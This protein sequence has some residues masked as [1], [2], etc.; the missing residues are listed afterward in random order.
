MSQTVKNFIQKVVETRDS[1]HAREHSYRPALK[2]LFEIITELKVINEPKRSEY[3]APDFVFLK[4]TASKQKIVIAYA[5]AKDITV[6]LDEIEKSEQMDRYYGYSNIIL[7]NGLDF[8]FY[9]NTA[10]YTDPIIIGKFQNNAIQPIESSFQLLEDTI[11]DFITESKEP[12]KSGGVLAKV[13]AGKGRRIRDN[14]KNYLAKENDPKNESLLSVYEVIKKLL[15]ADLDKTK[16]ADMYA[17]TLVYGLFVAKYYDDTPDTFSRQEARDLVPSSNPF[18]RHFFDHIAG[19]SFDSRIEWIVNE[20]CEEFIHADVQAIVHNYYK[21]EKEDSRDPII[22]FYEDFL[23]E[24]DSAERKKMGVFYTPLPVVRFIVRSVDDILKKEFSLPQGLVDSSR[25]EIE[26]E[27]QGKKKKISVHKVQVLDPATGTGTFLNEAILHIKKSFEGQEGRWS[28]YVNNDLL[29]RLHGFE[30]MMASYTI[31]H[32]KL[33]STLRE[34]G[35]KMENTRL[36]IY[37]TN[38]LEKGESAP[39]TLFDAFGFGKAIT[40]ESNQANKVKNELP[41]MVVIGNPPYSGVSSNETDHANSLVEKYKIEPGGN[42]K[43]QER[44]HWLNDDYVKFIAFAENMIV[45]NGEGI[46]GFITNHGYLDNPTFRGMRWYLMDT[47]DFIYVID[48]HGNAKKKEVSPDGSKDENV[49]AIQQGVS[50]M[51][52]VKTGK[53]KKGELAKVYRFDVWGKRNSK[54]EQLNSFSI[55]NIKWVKIEARLPNLFFTQGGSIKLEEEYQNG[56]SVN[57]L[58]I[59][60]STGIVTMGDGFIIDENKEVLQKRVND[61]LNENISE[62]SLTEKYRLGKNYAEWVIKNKKE[63]IGDHNKIAPFAYRPFDNRYTYFDNKLVWR[64]RTNTMKHFITGSNIGLIFTRQAIGGAE[65]NHI[66][67]SRN[68]SDNRVFFSNKGIP[69]EAPLYLYVEDGSKTPNLKKEIVDEIEKNVGKTLPEDVFDYIYAVLHSPNYRK[70]YKEFLKIDF[71]R[72][73]YPK[74][75]V[76]FK[77]LVELGREL[78][79]LHL[80]ESPK[81]KNF[82]TTYPK[83]GNDT[84]EKKYPKYEKGKVYI[85]EK[86]YFGNVSELIW[87]FY[88]GGYQPAQKWLKDRQGCI[89]SNT[90]IEHY[91]KIIVAL[92][93]TGRVMVEIDKIKGINYLD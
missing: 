64:P 27:I 12:I 90:D 78:R 42:Q 51:I 15:L 92:A 54:F 4:N 88:I 93:E 73:P 30:L 3:G 43:L 5:E 41:I 72:A 81:I 7:T 31:A 66:M 57:D 65:Y 36:G 14:I 24:Y 13:M 28:Q 48:L 11:K 86:Q 89:L 67:V 26:K 20:L 76:T 1:G 22:H 62:S 17:Q 59:Q 45:K 10:R 18:L 29:P 9:R 80:L 37:L 68:M 79:E 47:F 35:A 55:K 56:F 49:F 50:I 77:K 39:K 82:V 38:S 60:N 23:Q 83:A 6:S 46:V 40:E 61:F 70:K 33:S 91:Q 44:K 21:V 2:E 63:I 25:V 58:F 19:S 74:N 69:I 52:A 34:S 8:R 84:I 71:P 53:K 85:N 32:L 87:N 16:F 75:I